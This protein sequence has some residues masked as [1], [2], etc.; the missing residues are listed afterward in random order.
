[1]SVDQTKSVGHE[2][3]E[4]ESQWME[5]ARRKRHRLQ[6]SADLAS[7]PELPYC[8]GQQFVEGVIAILKRTYARQ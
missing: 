1:M 3:L 5:K 7:E 8:I 4:P 2:L 6:A